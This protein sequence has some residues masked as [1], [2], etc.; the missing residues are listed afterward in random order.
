MDTT[1]QQKLR[2]AAWNHRGFPY[3]PDFALPKLAK[4]KQLGAPLSG[5]YEL[6]I[7]GVT[8]ICQEFVNGLAVAPLGQ[9]EQAQAIPWH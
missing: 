3:N 8:Y 1:T 6:V 5:E 4:Q 7:D 9:W 2:N